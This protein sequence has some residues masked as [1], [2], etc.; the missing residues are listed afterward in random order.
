MLSFLH[1]GACHFSMRVS[2]NAIYFVKYIGYWPLGN[3]RWKG[4]NEKQ[5]RKHVVD[6]GEGKHECEGK[7][8]G[9]KKKKKNWKK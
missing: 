3:Q 8:M 1:M 6:W 5:I 4:T 2:Y 7:W 9:T